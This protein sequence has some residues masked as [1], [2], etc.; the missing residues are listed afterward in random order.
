[1]NSVVG[2]PWPIQAAV[3]A[4]VVKCADCEMRGGNASDHLYV[5]TRWGPG[6]Q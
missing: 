4:L 5:L 1:M 6:A 2:P 3:T